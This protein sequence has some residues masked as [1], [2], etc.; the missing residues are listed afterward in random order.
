MKANSPRL[1]NIF[2]Y[3]ISQFY[4][5]FSQKGKFACKQVEYL[6]VTNVNFCLRY[7]KIKS[8]SQVFLIIGSLRS[9]TAWKFFIFIPI[10]L[11]KTLMILFGF[12]R[13][14][15]E[16]KR[17]WEVFYSCLSS[18]FFFWGG[19]GVG[20]VG[21][22]LVLWFSFLWFSEQTKQKILLSG[23]PWALP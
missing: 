10:T 7:L 4:S 13:I 12:T 18:F 22:A 23:S 16:R 11:D 20:E 3:T 17:T 14:K 19:G 21:Q 9:V 1:H 6:F 2:A 8:P 15:L 5:S